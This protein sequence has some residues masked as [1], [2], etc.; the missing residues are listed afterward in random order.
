MFSSFCFRAQNLHRRLGQRRQDDD[1]LPVL[2]ERGRPDVADHRI[3]RRRNR[4]EKYQVTMLAKDI[5]LKDY[6]S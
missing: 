5:Q 6:I 4:L 2:D 1:P 3:K